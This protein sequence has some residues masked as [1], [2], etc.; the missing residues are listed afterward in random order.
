MCA[1]RVSHGV[2][3]ADLSVYGSLR[4]RWDHIYSR[5]SLL[6]VHS[7]WRRT[8]TSSELIN[9]LVSPLK[10]GR[11]RRPRLSGAAADPVFFDGVC[12]A[13]PKALILERPICVFLY[14]LLRASVLRSAAFASC[15][16][17][18]RKPVKNP[19]GGRRPESSSKSQ[20][21]REKCCRASVASIRS[22]DSVCEFPLIVRVVSSIWITKGARL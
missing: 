9:L 2:C 17:F 12:D 5:S 4:L 19:L 22:V 11:G 20:P 14:S 18:P 7:T 10:I 6:Q 3:G 1:V 16:N 13:W 8:S 21:L 15:S